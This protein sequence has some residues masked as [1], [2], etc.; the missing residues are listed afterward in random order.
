MYTLMYVILEHTCNT[1]AQKQGTLIL[2]PLSLE[3][4]FSLALAESSLIFFHAAK[5]RQIF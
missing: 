2:N 3:L 5:K 4:A 1:L